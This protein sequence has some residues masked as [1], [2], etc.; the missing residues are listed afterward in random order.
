M[1]GVLRN[2]LGG[3]G[4]DQMKETGISWEASMV[5]WISEYIKFNIIF[6]LCVCNLDLVDPV[7]YFDLL[8]KISRLHRGGDEKQ[9]VVVI[10]RIHYVLALIK[11]GEV[12]LERDNRGGMES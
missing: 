3:W 9:F 7:R 8:S 12:F 2:F 1:V 6:V 10:G 4:Q 5:K 11:E